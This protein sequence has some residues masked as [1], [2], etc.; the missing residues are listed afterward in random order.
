MWALA[1][2]VVETKQKGAPGFSEMRRNS[3]AFFA[4]SAVLTAC[5]L[6]WFI[7]ALLELTVDYYKYRDAA[8]GLEVAS[9]V[10]VLS[11]LAYTAAAVIAAGRDESA[12]KAAGYVPFGDA[13]APARY[14]NY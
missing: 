4:A 6:S 14:A 7:V 12:D 11:V 1:W 8:R 3:V 2:W 13:T 9:V 10:L 5:F